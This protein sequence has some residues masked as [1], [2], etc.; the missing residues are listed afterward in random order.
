[1]TETLIGSDWGPLAQ[2]LHA[3]IPDDP[4]PW[5]DN[6]F[7]CFWDPAKRL[8]GVM[9]ISASPNAAGGRRARVSVR[10]GNS[11]VEVIEKFLFRFGRLGHV[12][13]I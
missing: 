6:A 3:D 9:H 13:A 7:L 4:R 11:T 5:R 2:P 1:M 8:T 12:C 10:L